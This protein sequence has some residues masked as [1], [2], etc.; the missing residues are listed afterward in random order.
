MAGST[1]AV[2]ST[3]EGSRSLVP[4]GGRYGRHCARNVERPRTQQCYKHQR[5]SYAL[6]QIHESTGDANGW[7]YR[8]GITNPNNPTGTT[9]WVLL[10]ESELTNVGTS[11]TYVPTPW[12]SMSA[13]HEG[14]Q[15]QVRAFGNA[16][17][18]AVR[19]DHVR[20]EEQ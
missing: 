11:R 9:N 4:T 10:T 5:S 2:A 14:H 15:F 1:P 3:L 12:Y 19:F 6:P 8:S 7:E 13:V 18:S 16:L 20:G 17:D